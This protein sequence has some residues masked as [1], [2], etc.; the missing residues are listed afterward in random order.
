MVE[1]RVDGCD[2]TYHSLPSHLTLKTLSTTHLYEI[3]LLKSLSIG[4]LIL[5][6]IENLI[7]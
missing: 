7:T 3:L 6:L 4:R 2:S 1:N 5:K